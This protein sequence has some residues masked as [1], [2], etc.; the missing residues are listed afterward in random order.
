[1]ALGQSIISSDIISNR[2]DIFWNEVTEIPEMVSGMSLLILSK[3]NTN[4]QD[5]IQLNKILQA[6]QLK[7]EQYYTLYIDKPVAWHKLKEKLQPKVVLLFGI[8]PYELGVSALFH[9]FTPNHFDDCLWIPS[10]SI[11]DMEMQPDTKK[12]LW[13]RALK[14]IFVDKTIGT[15]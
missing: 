7:S 14:P 3:P 4:P 13:V 11:A 10:L 1:M 8:H 12:Q 2:E 9:I 5:E 6:C 15:I